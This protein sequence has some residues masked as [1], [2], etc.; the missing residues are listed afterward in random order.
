[1]KYKSCEFLQEGIHFWFN[2]IY[3]CCYA[4]GLKNDP[5]YLIKEYNGEKIDWKKLE[6][7]KKQIVENHKKGLI[8]PHCENCV[9]LREDDWDENYQYSNIVIS[10]WTNC[11]CNCKYCYTMNDK[12]FYNSHQPYKVLP[13]LKEMKESNRLKDKALFLFGGGE[14]TMLE[15]LDE[16]LDFILENNPRYIN[17]NSSGIDYNRTIAKALK[18]DLLGLTISIDAGSE[19]VY[20]KIKQQNTY[21]QVWENIEKYCSDQGFDKNAIKSKYIIYPGFNDDFDEVEKWLQKSIAAGVK[22]IALDVESLWY[23]LGNYKVPQKVSDLI[24]YIENRAKE[25]KLEVLFY[26]I[27]EQIKFKSNSSQV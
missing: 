20:K 8:D 1:M 2:S 22:N 19:E 10:H 7:Y 27:A 26:S 15:E 24:S 4:N 13:L 3:M 18:S 17:I 5:F 25:L 23:F 11:N 21:N 14:P 6:N 16:V 12:S 9:K